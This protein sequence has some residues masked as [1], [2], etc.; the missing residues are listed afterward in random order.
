MN[1][2]TESLLRVGNSKSSLSPEFLSW[3]C[4]SENNVLDAMDA[5]KD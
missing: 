1:A 2:S 3:G 5:A 4:V